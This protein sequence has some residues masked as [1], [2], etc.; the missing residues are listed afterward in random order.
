MFEA[1]ELGCTV[2]KE[3]YKKQ[4]PEIRTQLLEIQGLLKE[5]NFPVII[6]VSGVEGAG[7]GEVVN[8]L[9][10]WLDTRGLQTHAFWDDTDEERE[11]PHLWRFW[12]T[13]PPRGSIGI[14]FGSWYTRPIVNRVFDKTSDADLDTELSRI[15]DLEQ[16]LTRDGALLVKLWFHLTKK[17]QSLRLREDD[18]KFNKKKGESLEQRYAKHYER[19]SLV[20]EK[21]IRKTDSGKSPW[22]LIDASDKLY[23]DL[24]VARTLIEAVSQRLRDNQSSPKSERIHLPLLSEAPSASL[25][26]LDQVDLSEKLSD[27]EYKKQLEKYQNRLSELTWQARKKQRSSIAVFE[28]WDAAGKGGAIR[29]ITSAIDARLYR[30]I[31]VAA[32]SDE[33]L[34]QHYLWRFWRHIPRAGY[35]TIYDRS[36]YGRVLVERVEGYAKEYEWMRSYQEINSFEE[37]MRSHGTLL[38]KFWIHISQE[39][40]LKRFKERENVAWKQYKITDDDWRNREKWDDYKLAVNEMISRTSTNGSRWHIIPGNNKKF[41]RVHILKILCH[42]LEKILD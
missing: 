20:S 19:F 11:R 42:S 21:A 9:N 34:A 24:T 22:Y 17:D 32:P 18:K 29:R 39:E 1:V 36:W 28:G 23:R 38:N 7:K 5:A 10:E 31:S 13:L 12:R 14:M 4:E 33:E 2:P 3:E 27:K 25:T 30:T 8:R 41:A 35:V 26:I 40:Q 16:M 15:V 37:Q 6:I